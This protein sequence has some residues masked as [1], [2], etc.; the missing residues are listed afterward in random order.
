MTVSLLNQTKCQMWEALVLSTSFPC[1]ARIT[2]KA[3]QNRTPYLW[4]S[5]RSGRPPKTYVKPEAAITI[6]KPLMMDSVSSETCWAI[7]KHWNNKFYY[8]VASCWL[9]LWDLFSLCVCVCVREKEIERK[10]STLNMFKPWTLVFITRLF[11][12][13]T[14]ITQCYISYCIVVFWCNTI[15]VYSS[16]YLETTHVTTSK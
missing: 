11:Q 8:T 13:T 14:D 2:S 6:F 15:R 3:N 12:N 10:E 7:K 1:A 9:F 5:H 16:E 4:L